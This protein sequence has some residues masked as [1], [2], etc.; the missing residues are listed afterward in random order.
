MHNRAVVLLL[1]CFLLALVIPAYSDDLPLRSLARKGSAQ[2]GPPQSVSTLANGV[3]FDFTFQPV[4]DSTLIAGLPY[5]YV[6]ANAVSLDA[7][8]EIY[9]GNVDVRFYGRV[10][11]DVDLSS[12]GSV[13]YNWKV[14]P[15]N[16]RTITL[17]I[18]K[19]S[20]I[21]LRG[22]YYYFGVGIFTTGVPISG[23]LT[24][25]Y[26]T[27]EAPPC[28]YSLNDGS[29]ATSAWFDTSSGTG[30][31]NV[32]T[33]ATCAWTAIS[34]ASWLT[35]TSGATGT[36]SGTINYRVDAN[37]GGQ[38]QALI[39]SQGQTFTVT[40]AGVAPFRDDAM[41]MPHIV[42]GGGWKTTVFLSNVSDSWETFTLKFM[43]DGGSPWS[44]A[45]SGR[46]AATEFSDSLRPGQT[47][48]YETD[49]A[50]PLLEGSATLVPGTI[51]SSRISGFAVFRAAGVPEFE[52]A[53]PLT[54][55][56]TKSVVMLYDNS[57][58]FVS[59]I[60]L[61]NP[62]ST[63]LTVT[64]KVRD[65]AGSVLTTQTVTLPPQGHTA[66]QV[67]DYF[68]STANRRG[69]ILF[70]VN[71]GSVSVLG[72]RFNPSH[73]FTSFQGLTTPDMSKY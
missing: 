20:P 6:P 18:T 33:G 8:L 46:N 29:S 67:P 13:I 53:V 41:L 73:A 26:K 27:M 15:V 42:N 56:K 66:F 63:T 31:V 30:R 59:G 22:G 23:R 4:S 49:G 65:D 35:I 69:S 43:N 60:A 57:S 32:T 11:N 45:L 55:C 28:T 68:P 3:P 36:G 71:D 1:A 10:D 50:G 2:Y 54:D 34:S 58:G 19:T 39:T 7:V 51:G 44:I 62:R 48:V 25:T 64:A 40:Q 16:P 9:S 72:L 38:R 52:A 21:P 12:D 24:A 37:I 5:I 14:T 61:A 47:I 70:V 17:T